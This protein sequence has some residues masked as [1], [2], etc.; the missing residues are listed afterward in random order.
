M[1]DVPGQQSV[2]ARVDDA[3]ATIAATATGTAIH[4][5]ATR[6]AA[7]GFATCS[8]GGGLASC[9]GMSGLNGSGVARDT[10]TPAL[11]Q[12]NVGPFTSLIGGASHFCA[13]TATG[14]G[15][16]WG[17]DALVDT[18]GKS[19]N[20]LAP[21]LLPS[22]LSW[23]QISPGGTANQG[24]G[25]NCGIT[26][27]NDA[28]CWGANGSGQVG[29][30][31]VTRR[32]IPTLVAGGFKFSQI[33]TGGT[34]TCGLG[35]DGSAFCWGLNQFGQLGDGTFQQRLTPTAVGGGLK[36]S[37]VGT[38]E[39][40]SCGLTT[41]GKPT[42]W[43]SI[44]GVSPGQNTPLAYPTSPTLT[45]LSVGRLHACGLTADGTAYCW[46][47]NSA[48]QLGDSTQV[49]RQ[50]PTLVA[51]GLHFAQVSAGYFQT[52]GRTLSGD[53]ACW[54]ANEKGELGEAPAVTSIRLVPHFVIL[55]VTP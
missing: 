37:S 44:P 9:W 5:I 45:S 14:A 25:F 46:G 50:A 28:Y 2:D 38:G 43:G 24:Q 30:N 17:V 6:V 51:G 52:C 29:D 4:L 35:L 54:G 36:F 3:H 13:V 27:A 49:T 1:G 55:G 7:G 47:D 15:Y 18:S 16:C 12:G 11:T 31:T 23:L 19:S 48:G 10:T 32:V 22:I 39:S 34:H 26:V 53:V 40:W 33:A 21:T 20:T 8:L 42:C 41:D